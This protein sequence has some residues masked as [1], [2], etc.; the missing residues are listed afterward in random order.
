MAKGFNGFPGGNM[1]ALLKQAQK[2]QKDMQEAQLEAEA[3]QADGSAG[4]GA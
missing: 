1:Q 4:G 2:M 3:F